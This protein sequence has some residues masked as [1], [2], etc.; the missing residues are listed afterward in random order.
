MKVASVVSYEIVESTEP[1]IIAGCGLDM[2][3]PVKHPH[4]TLWHTSSSNR[5]PGNQVPPEA[6]QG[7][8]TGL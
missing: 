6:A 2:A 1:V 8:L 5:L 3:T 4:N 7:S